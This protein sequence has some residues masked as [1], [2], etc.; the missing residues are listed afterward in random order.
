MNS[1]KEVKNDLNLIAPKERP[2]DSKFSNN[3]D[4]NT[5]LDK[6]KTILTNDKNI[7][8]LCFLIGFFKVSG[9]K[10]LWDF[11]APKLK[12]LES[13][14]ILVGIEADKFSSSLTNL[15]SNPH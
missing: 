10:I 8:H 14:N 2:S 12:Q 11:I 13:I 9:F 15:E 5:L 4:S 3:S 6:F 7:V 1:E